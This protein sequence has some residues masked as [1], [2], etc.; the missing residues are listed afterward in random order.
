MAGE[1]KYGSLPFPEAIKFF[2]EKV[3]IPT[4][5]WDDLLG[6]MHARGFMVAGASGQILADFRVAV[7]K[8]IAEGTTLQEF[9][10]DFDAIVATH[11]WSYK[12]SRNWRSEVIFTTNLRT[13]YAAGRY[14]QMTD[15][16]VLAYRPW[17]QY[18][19]GDS[20]V[21]REL[22][23]SWDGL[24]LAADD[25]WW[26]V[27]YPPKGWG[28]KCRV[29][30][31]SGRDLKKLGKDG[32]DP[33]PNDGTY[34]WVDRNG[35]VHEL[36]RGVDPGWDYHVGKAAW[37]RSEALRLSEDQGPWTD[38]DP[39]GPSMFGR[40]EMMEVDDPQ[41]ALGH[42]VEKGNVDALRQALRDVLGGEEGMFV[43]PI[44]VAVT[45]TQALVDHILQNPEKRWDG[46]D[47]Y[48]PFIPELI[49]DPYEIWV[50]FARSEISGRVSL[51]RKYVKAIRL[52]KKT[53][54][55]LY[56][57]LQDGHWVTGNLFRGGVSGI[58][59]LRK[60]RLLWGRK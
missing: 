23:L 30:A 12:G 13:A 34:E 50:N 40:P 9:R 51:R 55:G 53:V 33:A 54:V 16:D 49:Q 47:A 3:D 20:R 46:R 57:E 48:F 6:D 1:V 58:K 28:C 5:H 2:R 39:A 29:F 7:E 37:G 45:V 14:R 36:P 8:A 31:L 11:G 25:P 60:G 22:H 52:D 17:W 38:L 26:D 10:K 18:R 44:G 32:P 4:K 24:V 15:P 35:V 59:N 42:P 19:H 21:P 27:H 43:D 41:G 56:A